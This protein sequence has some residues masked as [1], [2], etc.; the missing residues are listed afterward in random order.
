MGYFYTSKAYKLWDVNA[1][2]IVDGQD[3]LFDETPL[4]NPT[5]NGEGQIIIEIIH[6][7]TNLSQIARSSTRFEGH[8]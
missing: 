6:K 1:K 2:K 4:A 7:I 3:V 5:S 8:A